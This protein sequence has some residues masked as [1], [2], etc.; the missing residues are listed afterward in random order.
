MDTT[1]L[2]L[3]KSRKTGRRY[4]LQH[5]TKET[6]TRD[7]RL[8]HHASCPSQLEKHLPKWVPLRGIEIDALNYHLA[9]C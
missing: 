5:P 2:W 7:A 9:A 4:F 8:D 3:T 6:H 1:T